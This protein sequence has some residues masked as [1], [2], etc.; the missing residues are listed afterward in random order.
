[1]KRERFH[2]IEIIAGR[3]VHTYHA[4]RPTASGRHPFR[5]RDTVTGCS[6]ITQ[7]FRDQYPALKKS[8]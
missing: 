1:M 5:I 8:A 2:L 4:T 3:A 7:S 6:I